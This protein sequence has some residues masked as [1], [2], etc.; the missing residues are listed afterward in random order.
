VIH[1]DG[2]PAHFAQESP[3]R[4]LDLA[5]REWERDSLDRSVIG[6]PLFSGYNRSEGMYGGDLALRDEEPRLGVKELQL[7]ETI[8]HMHED[9]IRRSTADR[10]HGLKSDRPP[11]RCV[12]GQRTVD[13]SCVPACS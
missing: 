12:I 7:L 10:I 11:T 3:S 6:N 2:R 13:R 5:A 1:D 8:Q 4:D 9:P